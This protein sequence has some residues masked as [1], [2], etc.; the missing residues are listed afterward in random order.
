MKKHWPLLIIMIFIISLFMS[1]TAYAA[2]LTSREKAIGKAYIKSIETQK[3]SYLNK[4]KYPGSDLN[5]DNTLTDQGE[6]VKIFSPKYSKV[7]DTKVKMNSILIK[8]SLVISDGESLAIAKGTI[9]INLKKKGSTVY[10]FSENTTKVELTVIPLNELSDRQYLDIEKYLIGKYGKDAANAMLDFY[11]TTIDHAYVIDDS[12][13]SNASNNSSSLAPID[14][15]VALG[16]T[17]AYT[18]SYNFLGDTISGTFSFTVN[19]V[20][21][22]SFDNSFVGIE[23]LNFIKPKDVAI[24]FKMLTVTWEVKNAKLKRGSGD[25]N[26]F[27]CLIE[28]NFLGAEG[29]NGLSV[30]GVSDEG[31]TDCLD[32]KIE[33]EVGFDLLKEGEKLSYKVTGKILLPIMKDSDNYLVLEE[34]AYSVDDASK[35]Y[36]KLN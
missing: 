32:T 35:L 36:F 29:P 21:D 7:Y 19:K 17:C 26:I 12:D 34:D 27:K 31:F 8:C 33:D 6:S 10:A 13:D 1:N 28:P 9:G 20:E 2:A 5:M 18:T 25:G 11:E 22:I 3:V 14:R 4:Y 24:A 30:I 16:D 23:S 15:P